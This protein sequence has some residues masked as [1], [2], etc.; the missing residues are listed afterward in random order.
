MFWESFCFISA[1]WWWMHG[2]SCAWIYPRPCVQLHFDE[3]HTLNAN[4]C[5]HALRTRLYVCMLDK[6]GP[7]S[8]L[9]NIFFI[10]MGATVWL[11][12]TI[13]QFSS[14]PDMTHQLRV[15]PSSW[16]RLYWT[17]NIPLLYIFKPTMVICLN[18]LVVAHISGSNWMPAVEGNGMI[19]RY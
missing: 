4:V 15:P 16:N 13:F 7:W 12:R 10:S 14:S 11:W 17:F 1:C 18:L 3:S 8:L 19:L 6:R 5:M 2:Q 9:K